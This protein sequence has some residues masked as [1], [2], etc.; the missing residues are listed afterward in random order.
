MAHNEVA[1]HSET[2]GFIQ[3]PTPT[4]WPFILALGVALAI[5]GMVTHWAI[6]LLGVCLTLRSAAG[7][8]AQMF[9]HEQHEAVAIVADVVTLSSARTIKTH[10]H[11]LQG[12]RLVK[13]LDSYNVLVGVKGG[14]AGGVAMAVPAGIFGL[15]AYHS[16][17]YPINLLAAGGFVSWA[18]ESDAFLAQFHL[19]GLLAGL[20][21]HAFS[22][23]LVGLLY[24]AML[25]M[26]PRR[27]ILMAGF[28]APLLWTGLLYTSL[29][30]L[31]PI[32]DA[33]IRW[34]WFVVS[35]IAFGLVAGFVVNLQVK[36]KDPEFQQLPFAVRAGLHTD[37]PG[38]GEDA[39]GPG[40]NK[41]G[42]S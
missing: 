15:L 39:G 40:K 9:P 32:L 13:P 42:R 12:H 11:P 35:Q 25:P 33:R 2:D 8:F 5:T 3:L 17:W 26:F 23:I 10:A 4:I 14:I 1:G 29:G 7:W 6:T 30:I 41:D 31:S 36:V 38:G 37:L 28:V 34:G 24:G 16:I 21:I 18:S 20:A 22:S 19:E 27:P